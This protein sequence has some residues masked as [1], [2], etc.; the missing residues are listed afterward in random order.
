MRVAGEG[1][2]EVWRDVD[3]LFVEVQVG[4]LF[5][6]VVCQRGGLLRFIVVLRTMFT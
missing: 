3:N 4:G 2:G 1:G 6:G 5:G